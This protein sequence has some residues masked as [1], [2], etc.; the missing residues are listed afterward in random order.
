MR[1][2]VCVHYIGSLLVLNGTA[3][4]LSAAIALGY[5]DG[6]FDILMVSGLIT[7]GFG[8]LPWLF[9][10]NVKDISLKEA[11]LIVAGAWLALS[12]AGAIPFYL[13]GQPFNFINALFES[14]SGYTTTGSSILEDIESL[15][16]GLL[17]WRSLTHALGGMGIIVLGIAILPALS[18]ISSNLMKQEYSGLV[19][20]PLFPRAR[21][22]SQ[23]LLLVYLG[24]IALQTSFLLLTGLSWFD[25]VTTAF[26]T[27]ATG[28]FSVR[29][30]SIASYNN[31]AVEIIVMVFMTVSGMNFAFLFAL[32]M[33]RGQKIY[34]WE[35]AKVYL[36]LQVVFIILV[37][38]LIHGKIY[39]RWGEALRYAAFQLLSVGTST[40]FA[41]A[42][43]S[44][45]TPPAHMI[46][47]FLTLL[48]A[49]AGS[50]SGGIKVDRLVLYWKLCRQNVRS[51]IHPR[52]IQTIRMDGA[53]LDLEAAKT[54]M[55]FIVSYLL[56]IAVSTS[57]LALN[58]AE[59]L[60]AF[61][62]SAACMGNVGP[63][64]GKVGSMGNYSSI[65]GSGKLILSLVMIIGRL[66]IFVLVL[67]FTRNFWKV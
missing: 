47:V 29:N 24:L 41:T 46:L 61:S 57:F 37:T 27:I 30:L 21:T 48:C 56:I 19:A 5:A 22:I 3:M 1:L 62:G 34:G 12:F 43:S 6:S 23:V 38:V 65:S 2:E 59:M 11:V 50:T 20:Q 31:L 9:V 44:V 64:L 14:V 51:L 35:T 49:C 17:F 45:W 33:R 18:K 16:K 7:A 60:D 32:L 4:L 42:D 28:G 66:E 54:A 15:P 13:Y 39:Q 55:L 8:V 58:G 67:P 26:G 53:A 36:S 10:P 63:G 40:G 52:M 25:A